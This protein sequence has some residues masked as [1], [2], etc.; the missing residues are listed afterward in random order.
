MTPTSTL[1][2][3]H[4]TSPPDTRPAAS[5]LLLR[6]GEQTLE[7]LMLRRAERAGDMRSGAVVF[8][9]GVLDAKDREAHGRLLGLDDAVA[10]RRLGVA[11]GG[12]DYW[13]AALRECFEEVGLLPALAGGV[14]APDLAAL[15]AWREPLNRGEAGFDAFCAEA[16][17]TFDVRGTHYL[18]H[19]LT[20]PGHPKRFDTRFF[21]TAAP[22]G[23][24]AVADRGEALEP[25]WLT[26]QQALERG[27]ARDASGLLLLPVTRRTLEDLSKFPHARAALDAA[28]A[29]EAEGRVPGCTMPRR[30]SRGGKLHILLPGDAQYAEIAHRDPHGKWDVSIDLV[31]GVPAQLSPRVWRVTAGNPGPMTGPGTN[32]YLVAAPVAEGAPRAFTVIDPGPALAEH[33]QALI[34][35]A[36]SLNG[37]IER[38]LVTHTH[39]DHSPAAAP[40]AA[41]T[42][43]PVLGRFALHPTWQDDSFAPAREIADGERIELSPGT[44]LRAIHTPGHASNHICWLLEAERLLFTGDHVMQGSTVVINPPDGDMAAY[45]STLE[46]LL[47]LDIVHLAPGHGWLIGD[48]H[49]VIRALIAHRLKREDKVL[50]A[51]RPGRPGEDLAALLPRVY[52]DVPAALHPVAARSLLAHLL[53]LRSDG[54]AASEGASDAAVWRALPAAVDQQLVRP[55]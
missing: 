18:S 42:G 7:V 11:A 33:V 46:G 15:A 21:V 17:L 52:D 53:K 2:Q 5:L 35:A 8:P 20:P 36:A 55:E 48:P 26:P 4:W 50:A 16:D 25:M 43:A 45:L 32:S 12:L 31:P 40:L 27:R 30:A 54:R 19:W 13:V 28:R 41:A 47:A 29:A 14:P 10:S 3:P 22:S 51:L 44:T 1:P 38:I 23:Q 6:G 24:E 34:A 39:R 9:G 37:R 49:A